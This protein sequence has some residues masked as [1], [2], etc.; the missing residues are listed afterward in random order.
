MGRAKKSE[1]INPEVAKGFFIVF[2]F[3]LAAIC[4]LSLFDLAGQAGQFFESFLILGFGLGR[5]LV[6]VILVALGYILLNEDRFQVGLAKY[7][8][9]LLL[10]LSLLAILQWNFVNKNPFAL[11]DLSKGGGY[12]G[13]ILA[14]PLLKIMGRAGSL[15]ILMAIFISSL[16]LT[17]NASLHQILE[18]GSFWK[19]FYQKIKIFILNSRFNGKGKEDEDDECYDEEEEEEYEGDDEY[20]EE[21]EEEEEYED[22][23]NEE[24]EPSFDKKEISEGDSSEIDL[25]STLVKAGKRRK[26]DLPLDLLRSKSEKPTSGD[27]KGQMEVIEK[28][29]DNFGIEVEMGDVSVGPTVTQYTL[30]PSEGIKLSQITTLHN[31]LA[32]ALAAHPIRIEAP[33]PG[34]AL[35]GIEVPNQKVAAV[36]L[37]EVLSSADFKKRKNNLTITL[38]KD[39]SGKVWTADLSKMPHLLV[40]GSTGSGKSVCLNT[41]IVS[42]LYQNSPDDLRFILVDPKRVE[43]STYNGIPH[44][45]TPVI[46]NVPKTVNALKWAIGEMDRR[47]ELLSKYGKKDIASFNQEMSDKMPYLVFVIDELADLMAVA[48]AE[49]EAA[50]IRLAQM[51][52]AVGIHLVLAT[53]RPSVNIITGLIKANITTRIA[54]SVASNADSRTILDTSGAEKLLGRGDM[55]YSSPDLGKPK[56]LQ[57]VFIRDNEIKAVISHLKSKGEPIYIKEIIEKPVFGAA[58]VSGFEFGGG[59]SDEELFDEAKEVIKRAGKASASLLQRR[60]KIGYARAA[61]LL[62][63]LEEQGIIGPPDGAKPREVLIGAISEGAEDYENNE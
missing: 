18:K 59:N 35:V 12:A 37:R 40:A 63:L 23:E 54:F 32:L 38:G 2:L 41:L 6:P 10:I 33:I 62:D 36:G 61:R 42:L 30:K 26:I 29:L 25:P 52:R 43:F 45:L 14:Y 57:G 50:I 19:K 28:T 13:L 20:E 51:A 17:F 39:V 56:R 31:D 24:E 15:I 11:E 34:K 44:L 60:L 49:V 46:N 4:I 7:L 48:A 9:L 3:A 21:E 22:D 27:I 5:Y 16:L 58:P 55:L 8:G 1:A 47:F 53:Q